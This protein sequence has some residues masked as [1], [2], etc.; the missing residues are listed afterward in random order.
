MRPLLA[1]VAAL[2]AILPASAGQG[3]A[4]VLSSHRTKAVYEGNRHLPCRYRTSL[5]PDRCGHARDVAVFRITEYLAYEKSGQHGDP[6]ATEFLLPLKAGEEVSAEILAT[7]KGLAKGDAVR[8]DW[9]HE[10]VSKDGSKYP[11]RRVTLLAR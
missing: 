9:L 11:R 10:Y 5:C 3:S 7:A 6:K 4:E 2:V 8:L 1:L